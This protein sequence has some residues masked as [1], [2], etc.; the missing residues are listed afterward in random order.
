MT[1][2]G[3]NIR[4]VDA[5]TARTYATRNSYTTCLPHMD[6]YNGHAGYFSGR[7]VMVAACSACVVLV[8]NT[9]NS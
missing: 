7:V 6:I 8:N 9:M 1:R 3:D 4:T 5:R 2:R